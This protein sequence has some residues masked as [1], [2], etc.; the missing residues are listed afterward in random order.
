MERQRAEL[1]DLQKEGSAVIEE[2]QTKNRTALE[3][4]QKFAEK[5]Q[6]NSTLFLNLSD[7]Q[8]C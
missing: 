2:L 7:L 6:V 3:A 4:S 5:A 8:P 1:N